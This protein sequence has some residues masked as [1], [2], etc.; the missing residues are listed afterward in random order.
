[1]QNIH[2]LTKQ[3]QQGILTFRTSTDDLRTLFGWFW[4][5]D[6]NRFVNHRH[7]DGTLSNALI[8]VNDV[9]RFTSSTK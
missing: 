5:T 2:Q 6:T 8:N 4:L 3:E 7:P 9:V 1:M